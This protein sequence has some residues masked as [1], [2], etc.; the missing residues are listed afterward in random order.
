MLGNAGRYIG[1]LLLF[2]GL[3]FFIVI[4]AGFSSGFFSHSFAQSAI[5]QIMG[6]TTSQ[7]Q[8]SNVVS[9]VNISSLNSTVIP[10]LNSK[11]SYI[12][13]GMGC[14]ASSYLKSVSG[15]NLPMNNIDLY[16]YELI[17]LAIA[18]IG[19]VLMFF[20]YEKEKKLTAIGKNMIS[21]AILSV[22][23]F[24][25]PLSF[26]IPYLFSLPISSF[27]LKIPTTV[28]SSFSSSIL[29]IDIIVAVIGIVL[30]VVAGII[31]KLKKVPQQN[32]GTKLIVTQK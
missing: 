32:L 26:I 19:A 18:I 1:G 2:L 20:S 7:Y 10:Q 15:I 24:Y 17:A 6:Y 5:N 8:L 28:L 13:C 12:N 25:I 22:V 23:I 30:W 21:T 9:P 16:H 27:S 3:L 29:S 14:L 31:K 4:L 11:I